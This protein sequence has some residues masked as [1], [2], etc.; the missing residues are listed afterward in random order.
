MSKP[1][2]NPYKY[3]SW[4]L[5]VVAGVLF[6][7]YQLHPKYTWNHVDKSSLSDLVEYISNN[8]DSEFRESAFSSIE[9]LIT[10]LKGDQ[11]ESAIDAVTTFRPQRLS[12]YHILMQLYG[13][14]LKYDGLK[15]DYRGGCQTRSEAYI[16]DTAKE[17]MEGL[18][19]KYI[20]ILMKEGKASDWLKFSNYVDKEYWTAEV[21]L[22]VDQA[23]KDTYWNTEEIGWNEANKIPS[24]E[25]NSEDAEYKILYENSYYTYPK[26][27]LD[28]SSW[29]SVEELYPNGK[30][31]MT[32]GDSSVYVSFASVEQYES[33][34]YELEDVNYLH[35][36]REAQITQ[37]NRFLIYYPEG[38]YS[39]KAREK[40]IELKVAD[41]F[42]KQHGSLPKAQNI[43]GKYGTKSSITVKN[44]T[45]YGLNI[46]YSGPTQTMLFLSAGSCESITL[47]N[48][49][50]RIAVVADSDDVSD[51]AGIDLYEG[52]K[53]SYTLYIVRRYR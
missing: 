52:G 29:N 33:N 11:F 8:P 40:I 3:V 22:K 35:L 21:H 5:V 10:N 17:R 41:V 9:K 27:F 36:L 7:I 4:I 34:G 15:S 20:D 49:E 38:N 48:G 24:F 51:Y 39:D 46:Y 45:E 23:E 32:K 42:D 53:Y 43:G 37:F 1:L 30:V 47:P 16:Y 19:Q 44:D 28:V 26:S 12:D 13:A 2:Y 6:S 31:W 25:Y 50:Y 14:A 18:L